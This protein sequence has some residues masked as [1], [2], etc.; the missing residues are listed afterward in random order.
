MSGLGDERLGA[1]NMSLE[2]TEIFVLDAIKKT[3]AI[4]HAG[5]DQGADNLV[6]GGLV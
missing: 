2:A 6:F 1:L 4:I 3:V 5:M